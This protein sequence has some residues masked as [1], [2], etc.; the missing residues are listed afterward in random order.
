MAARD[1]QHVVL[2]KCFIFK[3]VIRSVCVVQPIMSDYYTHYYKNACSEC[4]HSYTHLIL[5]LDIVREPTL[6]GF[7][8]HGIGRASG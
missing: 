3:R 4:D 6:W 1:I 7:C 5:A 2:Y 8:T